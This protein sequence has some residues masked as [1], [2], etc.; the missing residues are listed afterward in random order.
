MEANFTL[1]NYQDVCLNP[2]LPGGAESS[3]QVL[4]Q[5]GVFTQS[6]LDPSSSSV[7]YAAPFPQNNAI[8]LNTKGGVWR[9]TDNGASWTQMKNALNATQGTDR[10][11][12]AV[13]PIT[14]GFT[15][16]YVGDGN[17]GANAARL[18]RTDDAVHATD[19][20]F[21]DLTALQDASS[22]PNKRSATAQANAGATTW[23]T[24]HPANL[25][26]CIW[27][28]PST[29]AIMALGTT[30]APSSAQPMLA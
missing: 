5:R 23:F 18:F 26:S 30:A 11:S 2:T 16:M 7:V 10:A 8:P 21:T 17:A 28:V 13:T 1:T 9:S 27:A 6:A 4:V 19:A 24:L 20:S 12:F 15:R 22:A 29:T 14:G 25:T 3:R